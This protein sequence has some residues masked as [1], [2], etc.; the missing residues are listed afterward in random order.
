MTVAQKYKIPV[1]LKQQVEKQIQLKI[2]LYKYYLTAGYN[3]KEADL[4]AIKEM[5]QPKL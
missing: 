3:H 2:N 1:E 5:Y 4:L